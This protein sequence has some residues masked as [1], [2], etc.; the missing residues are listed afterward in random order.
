M[1]PLLAKASTLHLRAAPPYLLRTS[2][3]SASLCVKSSNTNYLSPTMPPQLKALFDHIRYLYLGNRFFV[4]LAAVVVLSATGFWWRPLFYLAV[5]GLVALVVALFYDVY[6][7]YGLSGKVTATRLT[8]KVFSLSDE[9]NVRIRLHNTGD[10]KISATLTDEL[11]ADLQVRDHRIAFELDPQSD[12]ELRYPIRP[13]TRGEYAFG[14]IN[15]FLSTDWQL[16]ER[17]LEFPAEETVPVYPSIIQMQEF[18][19]KAKTTVPAEGRKRMRR[20]AKSYEFD[21]IKEYVLGDDFRSINW[22]ATGRQ[23][24]LMVNQYEDER[25]QRVF[26]CIDKGRTMLMPFNG[27]SLLD[28]AINASLALS[29]VILKR[30]DRAGLLTFS[31]KIGTVLPAD[32]KPDHLRRIMEALYRQQDRQ[33]E[34]N[35]DLL[36]YASRKL[37]G[38]RSLM[39]LFT[40]FESNYALD[41]VLP[42]LRRI[43]KSH[44]LVV[45]LFENTEV[46]DLLEEPT[47]EV[48]DV[49][50]KSTARRHLVQRSLMAARLRQN[51]IKVVLT[52]PENLTGDVI[53]QYLELKRRGLV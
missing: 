21:Q 15:L 29:N 10:K 8:P 35:Y 42:G 17:R 50:L 5:L 41:R 24:Q 2:A 39:I 11:P 31:D 52:R 4:G 47:S 30:Q 9:M 43:S 12:K 40:N 46:A 16:A 1:E 20:L 26:C 37:L 27:L 53:N 14:N 38:G 22:K 34:S 18:A 32:S 44:Q 51:G 13:M 28:Y 49:Y 7:L 19:L 48:E 23:N 33:M 3:P 45:I 25:A 6:Q 36:Y